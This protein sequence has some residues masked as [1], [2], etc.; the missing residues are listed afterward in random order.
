MSD[1]PQNDPSQPP[2][3]A[4]RAEAHAGA[5]G[6]PRRDRLQISPEDRDRHREPPTGDAGEAGQG[7]EGRGRR[8][9]PSHVT[10][11]RGLL[12]HSL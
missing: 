1:D 12:N 8:P 6:G 10:L 7:V 5:A 11:I 2:P 9:I 3:L 4:P